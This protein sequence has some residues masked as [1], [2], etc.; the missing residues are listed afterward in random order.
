HIVLHCAPIYLVHC[1]KYVYSTEDEEEP[2]HEHA[3]MNLKRD[4]PLL[5]FPFPFLFFPPLPFP[6]LSFPSLPFP[7]LLSYVL[8]YYGKSF[9]I[10]QS[11]NRSRRTTHTLSCTFTAHTSPRS[12][13]R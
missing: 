5:P 1:L 9:I 12:S 11:F 6:S 13:L 4:E 3:T 2:F 8:L 10:T 7:S